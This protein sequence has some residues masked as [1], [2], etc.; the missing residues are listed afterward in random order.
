MPV[1]AETPSI[2][3]GTLTPLRADSLPPTSTRVTARRGDTSTATS[4]ILPSSRSSAWPGLSADRISGC[5]RWTRVSSPGA[6]SA[7]STKVAPFA[8]HDR[9]VAE[10]ADPQ[11]RALQ[12]DQDADRPA[13]LGLDLT[14]QPDELAHALVAR[15]AHVD[16]EDVGAG[17]EQRGDHVP[18][19]GRWT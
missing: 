14:D 17:L 9:V 4:L 2:V 19:G 8:Q 13:V 1:S 3:S 10:G 12:I 5:G 6:G 18:A 7:S 15:M 11:L 16:A